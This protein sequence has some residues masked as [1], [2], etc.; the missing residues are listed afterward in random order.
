MND[1]KKIHEILVQTVVK[2]DPQVRSIVSLG[3]AVTTSESC[4]EGNCPCNARNGNECTCDSKCQ[5]EGKTS[6]VVDNPITGTLVNPIGCS[7]F[8]PLEFPTDVI[9]QINEHLQN[10]FKTTFKNKNN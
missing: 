8:D 9:D 5:C 6:L 10:V 7:A 1:E 3:S 4:C 2:L